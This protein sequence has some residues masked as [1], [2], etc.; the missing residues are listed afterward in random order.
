[1]LFE[2]A[3]TSLRSLAGDDEVDDYSLRLREI[4]HE[5]EPNKGKS[6]M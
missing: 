3:A 6:V 2:V 4:G 5:L 1:M